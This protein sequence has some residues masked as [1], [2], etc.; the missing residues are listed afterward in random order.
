VLS[1]L[2]TW[3]RHLDAHSKEPSNLHVC[4][5]ASKTPVNQKIYHLNTL[6][7]YPAQT[8][9]RTKKE[10]ANCYAKL[11]NY[12]HPIVRFLRNRRAWT[13]SKSLWPITTLVQITNYTSPNK[14]I[15]PKSIYT[16]FK[17]FSPSTIFEQLALA[18][19]N[20]SCPEIFQCI[21]YTFYIQDF[22]Q[23]ALALKT[24]SPEIFHCIE[25]I[26]YHSRFLSNFVLVL[27][28][29]MCPKIFHRLEYTFCIQNFW[30]TC[31]CPEKQLPWNFS[32][33][34][35]MCIFIIQ[36][37]WATFACPEKTKTE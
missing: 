1:L 37:F 36:E 13:R 14:R 10:L 29:R 24:V 15:A 20:Q 35:I 6:H 23:L 34:W 7:L 17:I 30:E 18:V 2:Y 22:Q 16:V 9:K 19:K 33:Y 26:F 3:A 32:L 12:R 31:A 21:E 25:Y 11:F 8:R 28:N 4:A 27:K 5:A